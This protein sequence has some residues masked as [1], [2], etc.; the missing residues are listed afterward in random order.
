MR[1]I[2]TL[3]C[4][5]ELKNEVVLTTMLKQ[6]SGE[7]LGGSSESF[8]YWADQ[9]EKLPM[10]FQTFYGS[11]DV[12]KVLNVIEYSIYAYNVT[13]IVLDNLQF[14]LSGQG[15]G[16][17]RFEMQDDLISQLR[18]IATE[19]NVHISLVIH[20]KKTDDGQDL[21]VGSIFGTSKATQEADNIMIIQNRSQFKLL[22]IKKNR[23]DGEVGRVALLFDKS[24]KRFVTINSVEVENLLTGGEVKDILSLK[25]K[26][27]GV[28]AS[29]VIANTDYSVIAMEE[30]HVSLLVESVED[31]N[32]RIVEIEKWLE[33]KQN[34]KTVKTKTYKSLDNEIEMG[35]LIESGRITYGEIKQNNNGLDVKE[36]PVEKLR[37]EVKVAPVDNEMDQMDHF[38]GKVDEELT[39][40]DQHFKDIEKTREVN[41]GN[42]AMEFTTLKTSKWSMDDSKKVNFYVEKGT[43]MTYDD[44]IN[45]LMVQTN[46]KKPRQ[47]K[48]EE[49]FEDEWVEQSRKK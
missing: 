12:K 34:T 1:G 7:E 38:E 18:T 24:S 44:I 20:P 6:I 45:E 3:W 9:F 35:D 41:S 17:E 27:E 2:P 22:D 10:Y 13:H 11:T 19:K 39:I 5:F 25:K 26:L 30:K 23:Y 4:S 37:S 48:S 8:E 21:T 40:F 33:Q 46:S 28:D 47:Q 36:E 49:Y 31:K 15:R 14:M 29:E 32:K 42:D 16:F 43:M